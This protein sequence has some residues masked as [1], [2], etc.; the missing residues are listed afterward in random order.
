MSQHELIG[1]AT[2]SVNEHGCRIEHTV[3]KP[4]HLDDQGRCC[5]RK[6]QLYKL[7][8]PHFVCHKCSREYSATGAQQKNWAFKL[9]VDG[10]Y[11]RDEPKGLAAAS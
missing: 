9:R 5:G 1:E 11:H 10:N 6:A 7:P 4:S 8:R 2:F 3:W